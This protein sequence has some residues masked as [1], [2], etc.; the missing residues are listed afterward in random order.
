MANVSSS[1]YLSSLR[2]GDDG[3]VGWKFAMAWFRNTALWVPGLSAFENLGV[4]QLSGK[5]VGS[6]LVRKPFGAERRIGIHQLKMQVR[7]V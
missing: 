3:E 2:K 1:Q 7:S 6:E 4:G 5:P